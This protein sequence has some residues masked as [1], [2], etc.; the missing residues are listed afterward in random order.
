MAHEGHIIVKKDKP[1]DYRNFYGRMDR[2]Q[3]G[4][5][6]S[7]RPTFAYPTRV[8]DLEEEVASMKRV[9]DGNMVSSDRRMEFE[10]RY[11]E[12]KK[13]VDGIRGDEAAAMKHLEDNKDAYY[14]RFKELQEIIKNGMPTKKDI[15]ERRISPHRV[16]REEKGGF[17]ALKKE[18]QILAAMFGEETDTTTLQREG[19]VQYIPVPYA[20]PTAV[21]GGEPENVPEAFEP[22]PA[23]E[24][25][26]KKRPAAR[27]K[28]AKRKPAPKKLAPVA[29]V[30]A[31]EP[32]KE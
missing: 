14:S 6:V 20:M 15:K 11:K 10:L 17:G 7:N 23:S 2:N 8:R 9:L 16:L 26:A 30:P 3:K 24:P 25:R 21:D 19:G 5:V 32:P 13:K 27:R 12:L 31:P 22:E 4:E 1:V 28:P 18:Y 29:E